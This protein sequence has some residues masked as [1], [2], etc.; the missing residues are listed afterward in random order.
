MAYDLSIVAQRI[1][2]SVLLL[3]FVFVFSMAAFPQEPSK[4]LNRDSASGS[5]QT[6]SKESDPKAPAGAQMKQTIDQMAAAG[7][8]HPTTLVQAEKAYLFYTRF[9]GSPEQVFRVDSRTISTSMGG[10]PVRIYRPRDERNLPVWVFFHGG[11]F[12][13]G[14][15]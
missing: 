13:A 14:N 8:L 7:V 3:V 11:G 2:Y 9:S 1:A 6:P 5:S 12:V 10:I 15:S 4:S